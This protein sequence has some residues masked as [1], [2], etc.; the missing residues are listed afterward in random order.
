MYVLI[1]YNI[2]DHK[3]SGNNSTISLIKSFINKTL[4]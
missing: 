3:D 4:F 2:V 1:K